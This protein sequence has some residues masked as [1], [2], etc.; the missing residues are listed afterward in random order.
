MSKN[1]LPIVGAFVV[2]GLLLFAVGLFLIGDRRMLFTDTFELYAEVSRVSG[3]ENGGK[4]RV[5]GM[6]AG[7]VEEIHVQRVPMGQKPLKSQRITAIIPPK[8]EDSVASIQN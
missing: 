7:E 6:D 1:R 8:C 5:G 4:V 3:L 2:G